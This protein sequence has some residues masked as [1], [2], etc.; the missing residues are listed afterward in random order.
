M[1]RLIW[2][3]AYGPKRPHNPFLVRLNTPEPLTVKV[4][5]YTYALLC[6][7]PIVRGWGC[8]IL[9]DGLKRKADP[10]NAMVSGIPLS[11]M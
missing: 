10:T 8:L 6:G 1:G 3:S 7:I 4:A 5:P 9:G 11:R 2:N